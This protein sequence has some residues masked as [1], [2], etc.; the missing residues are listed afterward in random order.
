MSLK[1]NYVF[2][3]FVWFDPIFNVYLCLCVLFKFFYVSL[4]VF[5]LHSY[6]QE[7]FCHSLSIFLFLFHVQS[8]MMIEILIYMLRTVLY[9]IDP[10]DCVLYFMPN[11]RQILSFAKLVLFFAWERC[12]ALLTFCLWINWFICDFEKKNCGQSIP[13]VFITDF[14]LL[15]FYTHFFC[16]EF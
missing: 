16:W 9:F 8:H 3:V 7:V 13:S 4:Q 2:K 12:S 1:K 5:T 14:K 10:N 11:C 6:L 15:T